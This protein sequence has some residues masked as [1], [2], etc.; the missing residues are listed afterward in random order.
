[1]SSANYLNTNS[2]SNTKTSAAE[3]SRVLIE[4]Y[5][6]PVSQSVTLNSD[7]KHETLIIPSTSMPS[8]G[9]FHSIN[10]R[11]KNILLH[12]YAL[13]FVTSA[14]SGT[15]LTGYFVP[16]YFF[17]TKLEFINANGVSDTIYNT[18]SFLR[19]N[20][21]HPDEDRLSMNNSAGNYASIAQRTS[22]SSQATINTFIV[23]LSSM[24]DQCRL[25]LL[26]NNHNLE[27]RVYMD[28]L[29]NV[30]TLTAGSNL[31]CTLLSSSLI[32]K[33]TR[34]D[35]STSLQ[36]LN[37]MAMK[38][39]DNVFHETCLSSNVVA[40]GLSSCTIV[41]NQFVGNFSHFIFV[42]RPTATATSGT[43]FYTFTQIQSFAL[44]DSG[45]TTISGTISCAL[46]SML[47]RDWIESSYNCENSLSAVDNGANFYFYSHSSDPNSCLKSGLCLGSKKYSGSEQLNIVF[48]SVLTATMNVD[49]YGY[50]EAF[51][52]TSLFGIKKR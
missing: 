28:S 15:S 42:C 18:E 39:Y 17:Y 3:G 40:S 27:L 16:A 24:I 44:L 13:Q 4:G 19:T 29:A 45:G 1:M 49:I 38:P 52:E 36:R 51:M 37:D 6:L 12:N 47:N 2:S 31:T 34:L 7:L 23:S 30:F 8:W 32:C 22:L 35:Q 10:L 9:A 46:A 50:R 33:I 20:C 5:N 43:G 21:L 48:K 41:L 26:N 11:D 14:V 25:N